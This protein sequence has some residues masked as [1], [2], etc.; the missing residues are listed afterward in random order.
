MYALSKSV[1]EYLHLL[2]RLKKKPV[3]I[4]LI[5]FVV[6]GIHSICTQTYQT[7][8]MQYYGETVQLLEF[9]EFRR[10]TCAYKLE[11]NC[12]SCSRNTRFPRFS[13]QV[14]EGSDIARTTYIYII[15]KFA[16][17]NWLETLGRVSGDRLRIALIPHTTK[18]SRADNEV[19]RSS[20]Y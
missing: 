1:F 7:R 15:W 4:C 19:K 17:G 13:K 10:T 3:F 12:I 14:S 20:E 9:V 6:L 2:E 8:Y 16:S 5:Y 18:M 11:K